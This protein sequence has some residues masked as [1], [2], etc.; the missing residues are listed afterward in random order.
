MFSHPVLDHFYHPRN[1]GIADG[2]NRYYLEQN[3]P[4]LIRIAFTL[5]IEEDRI[6]DV[7]FQAQSCVTTVACASAL[8][9]MIQGKSLSEV[10]S[11]TPQELSLVLRFRRSLEDAGVDLD[12]VAGMG[13]ERLATVLESLQRHARSAGL[14]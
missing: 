11:L 12:L 13:D 10:L 7:R 3:N 1:V 4:W 9:E 5:R 8:T 14:S 2:Y 6:A